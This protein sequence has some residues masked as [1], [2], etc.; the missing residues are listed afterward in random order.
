VAQRDAWG[1]DGYAYRD[2]DVHRDLDADGDA[3]HVYADTHGDASHAY[4]D[5]HVHSD[6]DA[7]EDTDADQDG[8][9]DQ[10]AHAHGDPGRDPRAFL[11]RGRA[12]GLRGGRGSRAVQI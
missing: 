6:A 7:D 5:T 4:Q 10:D 8:D 12:G 9:A 1:D 3:S 2:P 11:A